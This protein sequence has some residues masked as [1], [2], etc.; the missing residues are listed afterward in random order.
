[1]II[2]FY[3]FEEIKTK[4]SSNDENFK[5]VNDKLYKA[6]KEIEETIKL[7]RNLQA[8]YRRNS[9]VIITPKIKEN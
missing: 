8:L 9:F 3:T 1:M 6:I 2:D 4:K 5:V 7:K